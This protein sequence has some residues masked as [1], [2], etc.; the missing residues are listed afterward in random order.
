MFIHSK[1]REA[2]N[3]RTHTSH[4]QNHTMLTNQIQNEKEGVCVGVSWC[5]FPQSGSCNKTNVQW[6]P[7]QLTALPSVWTMKMTLRE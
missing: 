1:D 3:T 7:L 5:L 2:R 4:R 6:L